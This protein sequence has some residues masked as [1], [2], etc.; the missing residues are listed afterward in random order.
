MKRV[1]SLTVCVLLL[2]V[3]LMGCSPKTVLSG[4]DFQTK[5]EKKGFTVQDVTA[6][7]PGIGKT[8]MVAYNTAF[9]VEYF[10]LSNQSDAKGV[11]ENNK[12]LV[13]NQISNKSTTST[14]ASNY[15][16]FTLTGDGKFFMLTRVDNT[17][18]YCLTT[19]GNKDA[20]KEI[21][22]HLGY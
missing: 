8:V 5:M 6:S 1:L 16:T 14:S 10:E 17:V 3:L 12:S 15:E 19:S 21:F 2:S 9:Q 20:V 18:L 4:T 7:T 22:E 11:F 13:S